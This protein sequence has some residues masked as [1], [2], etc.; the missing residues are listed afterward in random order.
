M[1]SYSTVHVSFLNITRSAT[2]SLRSNH[3]AHKAVDMT[4]H[5]HQ[6]YPGK[7]NKPS[8]PSG[9]GLSIRK[10]QRPILMNDFCFRL[11]HTSLQ[12]QTWSAAH[13]LWFFGCKDDRPF[14]TN[15]LLRTLPL[16]S[17]RNLSGEQRVTSPKSVC[18]RGKQQTIIRKKNPPC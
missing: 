18:V 5:K 15:L 8:G 6:P 16:A 3:K 7:C 1:W 13:Q 2:S 9:R 4:K 17:S 12:V 14:A 11:L 10:R